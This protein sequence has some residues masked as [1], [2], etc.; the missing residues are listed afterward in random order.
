MHYHSGMSMTRKSDTMQVLITISSKGCFYSEELC[1][2]AF[3][4]LLELHGVPFRQ[5]SQFQIPEQGV[6]GHDSLHSA[7]V[8]CFTHKRS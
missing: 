8:C 1:P 6:T 5:R 7:E 3:T 2:S 4:G